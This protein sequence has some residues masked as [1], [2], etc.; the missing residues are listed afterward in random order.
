MKYILSSKVVTRSF[1]VLLSIAMVITSLSTPMYVRA[2]E[3]VTLSEGVPAVDIALKAT[4]TANGEHSEWGIL[5]SN[6]NNGHVPASSSDA[7][8]SWHDY[9]IDSADGTSW[10]QYDWE[11]NVS[12]T[13]MSIYWMSDGDWE[14]RIPKSAKVEYKD[15]TGAWQTAA[16][17]GSEV[18]AAQV[19][20]QYNLLPFEQEISTKCLRF[21]MERNVDG[22]CSIHRLQVWGDYTPSDVSLLATASASAEHSEWGI[23]ASNLNNGHE[24]VSSDDAAGSWHDYGIESSDGTSWVQ[25]DWDVDVTVSSMS[26][27]WMCD[28][29]WATR[30]PKSAKVEYKDANG[31]WQ[32]AATYDA[33]EMAAQVADQ[34]NMLTFDHQVTT[35]ALRLL[36]REMR[37]TSVPY[38]DGRF[39]VRLRRNH[40]LRKQWLRLL[41]MVTD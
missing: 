21:T 33:V 16:T 35:K 20:D 22:F 36:W 26:I 19:A 24:P 40:Y 4:A 28:G 34:Y 8:G 37:M 17:Y 32:A 30:I 14:F 27:Y 7:A 10:V 31:N 6:I 29:E 15:S 18:M 11:K 23:L 13:S 12:L 39:G 38:T 41:P 5:A 9:G 2:E 3:P 1:A 25:Y